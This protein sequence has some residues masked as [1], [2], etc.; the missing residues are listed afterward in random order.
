MLDYPFINNCGKIIDAG[1]MSY[2]H[3]VKPGSS[4]IWAGERT[5]HTNDLWVMDGTPKY[6]RELLPGYKERRYAKRAKDPKIQ[7][8]HERVKR[9]RADLIDDPE[10]AT[11]ILHDHEADDLLSLIHLYL[12][13]RKT[14]KPIVAVDKD[15]YQLPGIELYMLDHRGNR[16]P[17]SKAFKVPKYMGSIPLKPW[18]FLLIQALTGDKSD[19]IPRLLSSNGS[20]A[21]R[22]FLHNISWFHPIESFHRAHD[23]FGSDFH[24]NLLLL[25]MPGPFLRT[26]YTELAGSIER[27]VLLIVSSGYWL[28]P[29]Q[30]DTTILDNLQEINRA[31]KEEGGW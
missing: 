12:W 8:K 15:L 14:P 24:R 27:V 10:I 18:A 11:P 9:F 5:S 22:W 26:D 7:A 25:L 3:G 19:G 2:V 31:W 20:L 29:G 16:R 30:W 13:H 21:K 23:R 4:Y 1:Y 28:F 6:R 17:A